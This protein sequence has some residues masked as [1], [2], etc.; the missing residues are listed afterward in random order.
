MTFKKDSKFK[1]FLLVDKNTNLLYHQ[2]FFNVFFK[3]H[4]SDA[5]KKKMWGITH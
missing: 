2:R 1:G 4:L 5:T 3:K